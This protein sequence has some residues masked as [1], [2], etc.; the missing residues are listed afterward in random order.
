MSPKPLSA[1]RGVEAAPPCV[2]A[3]GESDRGEVRARNEDSFAVY[4]DLNLYVV[5]DGVAGRD[6][7]DVAS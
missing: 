1:E 3:R 2:E 6:H 5:A 4:D 7:G